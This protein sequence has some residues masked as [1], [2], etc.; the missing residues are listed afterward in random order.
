MKTKH[1]IITGMI[2]IALAGMVITGCKKEST[3]DTDATAAQDD[4]NASFM[5]NESKTISDGAAKGQATERILGICGTV[6]KRDTTIG[7]VLDTLVDVS[8]PGGCVS[9]DGRTRKGHILFWW[10]GKG[11]FQDSAS[12]TETWVNYSVYSPLSGTTIAIGNGS[13]RTL[14]NIGHDSA[15][16]CSWSFNANLTLNYS[17]AT[18]GK[19]TW[20]SSRTN[21]LTDV[22]GVHY[23]VINGGASGTSRTGVSYTLTITQPLYWTAYW[24]NI[25][26]GKATKNCDCFESGT[27][28]FSRTG[29]TYPLYL[30][31]T[32]GVG[33]CAHTATATI[34]G[35]TYPITLP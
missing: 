14:T 1:F 35:N 21:I 30:Q 20:T 26:Y 12:V 29:K 13:T 3:A 9:N 32:S 10:N 16:D 25:F 34:N 24:I 23:Y 15:G 7:G 19:A 4:A 8:F 27:V 18:T 31:F 22:S 2:G 33:N 6:T 5:L 17:G 28:E 11:Y